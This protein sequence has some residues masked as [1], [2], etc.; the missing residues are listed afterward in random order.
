MLRRL[1]TVG[2]L[3]R[4]H[5]RFGRTGETGRTCWVGI[6]TPPVTVRE[7]VGGTALG[8]TRMEALPVDRFQTSSGRAATCFLHSPPRWIQN[9]PATVAQIVASKKPGQTAP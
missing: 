3:R 9:T 8:Q 6:A 5:V 2:T 4:R 7:P 1:P